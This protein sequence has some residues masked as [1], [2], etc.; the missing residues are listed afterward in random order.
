MPQS[1]SV[2]SMSKASRH[3]SRWVTSSGMRVVVRH[4][5]SAS[6]S[7][8]RNRRHCS[9]QEAVSLAAWT[10]TTTWQLARLPRAPQYCGATATDILPSLG[11]DTPSITQAVGAM[12]GSMRSQIRRCTG[13]AAWRD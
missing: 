8:G 11:S 2:S 1:A 4:S 3:F 6:H 13:R 12:S 9:G 5:V 7:W 10:L